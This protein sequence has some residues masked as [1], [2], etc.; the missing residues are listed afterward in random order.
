LLT[1]LPL[2]HHS[3]HLFPHLFPLRALLLS[4]CRPF[5]VQPESL[6][7]VASASG[8]NTY[9]ITTLPGTATAV[10]W[11]PYDVEQSGT[12]PLAIATYT[13]S[14]WDERGPKATP[15]GGRMSVHTGLSFALYRPQSYT[16]LSCK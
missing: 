5:Q 13:L 11:S 6:T 10:V 7:L 14:M 12:V 8:G 3:T 4:I 16:P 1:R 9:P 15:T 2:S